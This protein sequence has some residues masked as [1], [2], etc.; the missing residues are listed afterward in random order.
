MKKSTM[1]INRSVDFF[2]A[3]MVYDFR[4]KQK[5]EMMLWKT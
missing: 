1:G 2:I 4:R 5:K 3:G